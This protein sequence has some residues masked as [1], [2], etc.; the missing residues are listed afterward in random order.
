MTGVLRDE[1]ITP[2]R[3]A[4]LGLVRALLARLHAD[5]VLYCHWKS[6]EHL[7]ESM[8]GRTDLDLL[9]DRRSHITLAGILA[10]LDFKRFSAVPWREYPGIED[11]LGMDRDTGTLVHLHVHYRLT[12]GER[13]IKG[14][15][16]PWEERVLTERVLNEREGIFTADPAIEALLLVT[17]MALKI[18]L[19]DRIASWTG[20]RRYFVGGALRERRWL[21][22]RLTSDEL[23][24]RT[25][26]LVGDLAARQL[27]AIVFSSAPSIDQ[28][29]AFARCVSPQLAERRTYGGL[30]ARLRRWGRE[31]RGIWARWIMRQ[32]EPARRVSPRGG[33]NVA[34]IGA[35][36]AGKST[37][38]REAA[39]WLGAKLDV[40]VTYG[41][42]GAGSAGLPRRALKGLGR[43]LRRPPRP[44][45]GE[46]LD[47]RSPGV[48][49]GDA[50]P[51]FRWTLQSVG[52]VLAA[53]ALDR[54]RRSRLARARRLTNMGAIVLSDRYPQNQFLGFNDGPSLAAWADRGPLLVRWAA[55]RERATFQLFN[56]SPPDLVIK[57]LVP[58][59]VAAARKSDTPPLQL[60]RKIAAVRALRFPADTRVAEINAD[61]PLPEV[62]LAV[63]RAI[64]DVL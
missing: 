59:D 39:K 60:L 14:Y 19:R 30:E 52:R 58:F 13:Y 61:A 4:V 51:V 10:E 20:R 48:D 63:K 50:E 56:A 49:D 45:P 54:E 1:R 6:N 41:G 7:R 28:L 11:Y 25:R 17:R 29:L 47:E 55:R 44:S 16:L 26:L 62:L 12:L 38:V 35:D 40:T 21:A 5:N 34:L 3:D 15:R 57:L 2:T 9:F 18:R 33:V 32:R 23:I 46:R 24:E 8:L 22:E 37:L 36:G 64:W 43:M 27:V 31:W 42:S 53:L